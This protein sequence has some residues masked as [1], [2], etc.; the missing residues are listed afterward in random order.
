[1]EIRAEV[2]EAPGSGT[3]VVA[4]ESTLISHGMPRPDN[5]VVARE[6]GMSISVDPSSVP[7]LEEMG[8]GRFLQWTRGVDLC[9][10]NLEEGALLG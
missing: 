4:L 1:M 9:L 6:A 2:A 5:L 8:P 7:L 10:P 3:P